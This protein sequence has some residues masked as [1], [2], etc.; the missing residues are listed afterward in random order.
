[1]TKTTKSKP[2]P[3]IRDFYADTDQIA[4][5]FGK[6]KNTI[7]RWIKDRNFPAWQATPQSP[8]MATEKEIQAWIAE[9]RNRCK[10]CE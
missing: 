3:L 5:R 1:M 6:S 10:N 4:A 8:Y 9:F 2:E 7:K